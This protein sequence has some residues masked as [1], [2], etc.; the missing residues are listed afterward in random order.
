MTADDAKRIRAI[1]SIRGVARALGISYDAA[2]RL[3]GEATRA[4]NEPTAD[5]SDLKQ[6]AAKLL[7]DHERRNLSGKPE[8]IVQAEPIRDHPTMQPGGLVFAPKPYTK[9]GW[10][11]DLH[12]PY[13]DQ[14]AIDAALEFLGEWRPDLVVIGGDLLDMYSISRF[15][16]DPERTF[17]LQDE[18]DA[19]KPFVKAVDALGADVVYL[20]GNHEE[21][22]ANLIREN[23]GL[24][25]MRA[26]EFPR[27]VELPPSW[28]VYPSQT[29]YR[30]S[31]LTLLHGD[32]KGRGGGARHIA[33]NMLGKLKTSILFGHHHRQQCFPEPGYDKTIRAGFS[34]G[35]LSDE[36]KMDYCRCPDWT[37]GFASVDIDNESGIFDVRQ[38]LII[39]GRFRFNGKTYG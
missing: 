37:T 9:A 10:L 21:R 17:R 12:F 16:K 35:H 1:G 15:D 4:T 28:T 3:W 11:S 23:P 2:D 20:L 27:A 22:L 29:H 39:G 13:Q 25:R 36:S 24:S 30:I 7:A 32:L 5:F 38:H 33:A 34:T 19:A 26:M 31:H 14:P 8:V 18:I 6:I